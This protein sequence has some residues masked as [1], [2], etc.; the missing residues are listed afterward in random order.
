MGQGSSNRRL[1]T[2]SSHSRRG[3]PSP[4]LKRRKAKELSHAFNLLNDNF[5]VE[6][7]N[8]N[9]AT[10]EE[11]MTLPGI[12]RAVAHSIV[13]YRRIIGKFKKVQDLVLVP[14]FG[15]AKLSVIQPE[16]C[17]GGPRSKGLSR[18][19]SCGTP[20]EDSSN[21]LTGDTM[22]ESMPQFID[23]SADDEPPVPTT[24]SRLLDVNSASIFELM[25]VRNINQLLAANIVHYR[26]KKG[27]FKTVED[28]AKVK[29]LNHRL[30]GDLKQYLCVDPDRYARA[31]SNRANGNAG[32]WRSMRRSSS[33]PPISP[34]A[35]GVLR[36]S[37]MDAAMN[38]NGVSSNG[39]DDVDAQGRLPYNDS[40]IYEILA[41]RCPRPLTSGRFAFARDGKPALRLASWNLER[42]TADKARNLGVIEVICRTILENGISIIA[43]QD[44]GD[45]Q[46]IEKICKELNS[47][48][49]KKVHE[50]VGPRGCWKYEV[51]ECVNPLGQDREHLGFLYDSKRGITLV[52]S[53]TLNFPQPNN[54]G[55][56]FP[57]AFYGT[58]RGA[59]N[60]EFS[61]LT[62]HLQSPSKDEVVFNEMTETKTVALTPM[63]VILESWLDKVKDT[64]LGL[65]IVLGD[66]NCDPSAKAVGVLQDR[67]VNLVPSGVTT[68]AA[69]LEHSRGQPCC[70]NVWMSS[71]V[72]K[73]YTGYYGVIKK[74]LWHL[75]IPNGWSWG[76]YA[77]SH[78]PVWVEFFVPSLSSLTALSDEIEMGAVTSPKLPS[79]PNGGLE[80]LVVDRSPTMHIEENED[81]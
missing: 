50:W 26:D 72:R 18:S 54:N 6:L 78:S 14:G 19:S 42:F 47:P 60:I 8:I 59:D 38:A 55:P 23:D 7:L 1:S 70:D 13:E 33:V 79:L 65:N 28:L 63:T 24:S 46:G 34:S 53:E 20:S 5:R 36:G 57:G 10:E 73:F 67:F 56:S 21:V 29:G 49:L 71:F 2:V 61:L 3:W 11:L 41:E 45:H 12:D 68:D 32:K 16:I 69:V 25:T 58:F 43:L 44:L 52:K 77:S 74:G 64:A 48:S 30:L 66:F 37:A 81:V 51:S 31:C 39:S 76:G 35:N 75:A 40:A 80:R 9:T 17:V 62:V 4:S 15:A 27:P 22:E